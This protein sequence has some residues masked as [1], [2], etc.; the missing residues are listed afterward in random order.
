MC[1]SIEVPALRPSVQ[2]MIQEADADGDGE[3]SF[4][5]K[6]VEWE[7]YPQRVIF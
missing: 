2:E 3:L 7:F 6:K 5:D 4:D 1:N